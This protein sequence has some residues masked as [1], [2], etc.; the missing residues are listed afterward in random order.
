MEIAILSI[1]NPGIANFYDLDMKTMKTFA[2]LFALTL[3]LAGCGTSEPSEDQMFEAI[4]AA[5]Q[6]S[7]S[8]A[9]LAKMKEKTKKLGCEK[10]GEKSYKC[11]IGSR[12]G[13]GIAM[14]LSFTKSDGKWLMMPA[15]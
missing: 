4:A 6:T 12:D 14:P 3:G 9:E 13:K 11:M 5:D 8:S 15:N 2:S 10:T 7:N 1:N